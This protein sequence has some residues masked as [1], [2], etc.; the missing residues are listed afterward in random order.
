MKQIGFCTCTQFLTFSTSIHK[1][2]KDRNMYNTVGNS[3]LNSLS[4]GYCIFWYYLPLCSGLDPLAKGCAPPGVKQY[5]TYC[6]IPRYTCLYKDDDEIYYEWFLYPWTAYFFTCFKIRCYLYLWKCVVLII[7][8]WDTH[9]FDFQKLVW[10]ADYI[11]TN[12]G[13]KLVI[14]NKILGVT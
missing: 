14:L 7:N 6:Y 13:W 8:Q 5:Q 10:S 12:A 11:L 4:S 9:K 1:V 3:V 2:T